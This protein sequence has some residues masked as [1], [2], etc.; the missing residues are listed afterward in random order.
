MTPNDGQLPLPLPNF[1]GSLKPAPWSSFV[2]ARRARRISST[3]NFRCTIV[4]TQEMRDRWKRQADPKCERCSGEGLIFQVKE[5]ETLL[6]LCDCWEKRPG[7][8]SEG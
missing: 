2:P 8:E 7:V 1:Q 5:L 3:E 4:I 6:T